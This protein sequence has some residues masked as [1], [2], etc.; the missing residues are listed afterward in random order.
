MD[1]MCLR[2]LSAEPEHLPQFHKSSFISMLC[3][4]VPITLDLAPLQFRL[5]PNV[6]FSA[7]CCMQKSM[8]PVQKYPVKICNVYLWIWFML[9]LMMFFFGVWQWAI[10]SNVN[11]SQ[12]VPSYKSLQVPCSCTCWF[13]EKIEPWCAS[14]PK[15]IPPMHTCCS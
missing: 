15:P 13:P 11:N 2:C 8:Q 1:A 10:L 4:P 9:F 12:R 3:P 5:N 14:N 7:R 6:P